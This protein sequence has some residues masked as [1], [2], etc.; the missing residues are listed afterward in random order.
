MSKKNVTT[1]KDDWRN[2]R[3]PYTIELTRG[4][5]VLTELD[6]NGHIGWD[7]LKYMYWSDPK[8]SELSRQGNRLELSNTSDGVRYILRVAI[9][10]NQLHVSCSCDRKVERLCHHAYYALHHII[11][12]SGIHYFHSKL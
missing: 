11:T 8:V 6:M 9:E 3:E 5:G 7:T 10:R 12:Q 4:N 2:S 1:N